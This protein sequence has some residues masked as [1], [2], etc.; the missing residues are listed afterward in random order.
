MEIIANL[1]VQQIVE[2]MYAKCK[3]ECV[4]P[5]NLDTLDLHVTFFAQAT[6]EITLAI[7]RLGLAIHVISDFL[8]INVIIHVP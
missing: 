4:F 3:L 5:V 1:Y 8:E 7:C 6:A 2:I